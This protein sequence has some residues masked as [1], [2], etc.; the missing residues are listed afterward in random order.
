MYRLNIIQFLRTPLVLRLIKPIAT[1]Y[2]GRGGTRTPDLLIR[3][4]TL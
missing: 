1:Y 3:S 2:N 4:Q